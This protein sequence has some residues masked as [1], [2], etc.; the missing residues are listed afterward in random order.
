MISDFWL[1]QSLAWSEVR[2]DAELAAKIEAAYRQLEPQVLPA[3]CVA[4]LAVG[5]CPTDRTGDHV[6]REG[7]DERL[8]TAMRSLM[9]RAGQPPAVWLAT[10][11]WEGAVAELMAALTG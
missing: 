7:S 2:G 3:R 10:D 1:A 8:R 11:N 5:T 4:L 6:P 9:K